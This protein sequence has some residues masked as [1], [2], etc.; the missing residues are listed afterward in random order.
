MRSEN[1]ILTKE[2][3]VQKILKLGWMPSNTFLPM[4]ESVIFQTFRISCFKKYYSDHFA[5]FHS[6]YMHV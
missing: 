1:L 5:Q 6:S 2:D 4:L 3:M